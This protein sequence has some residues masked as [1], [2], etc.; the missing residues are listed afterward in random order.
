MMFATFFRQ[1][2]FNGRKIKFKTV[3]EKIFGALIY[4]RRTQ[5]GLQIRVA[6]YYVTDGNDVFSEF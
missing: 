6:M 4:V 3:A 1:L 2:L 5:R